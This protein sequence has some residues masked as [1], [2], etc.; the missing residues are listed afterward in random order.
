MRRDHHVG[1]LGLERRVEDLAIAIELAV[2]VIAAVAQHLPLVVVAEIRKRHVV[3]LQIAAAGVVERLNGF[4]IG[5][6]EVG[7]IVVEVGV[8]LLA[9]HFAAAPVVQHA[10]RRDH[11]LWRL[12]G[13][14]LEELEVFD[15]RM[16]RRK[17]QFPDHPHHPGLEHRALERLARVG[18]LRLH[19]VA[20]A[21]RKVLEKIEVPVGAPEFA[22]GDG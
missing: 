7:I 16:R 12:R 20:L 2:R 19:P 15:M 9:H 3:D 21:T 4:A 5:L 22:V 8:S 17:I 14:G 10:R 1:R 13:V 11:R 6:R 18:C